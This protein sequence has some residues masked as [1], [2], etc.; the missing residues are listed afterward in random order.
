MAK[1]FGK[2]IKRILYE[3][4]DKAVCPPGNLK[5]TRHLPDIALLLK[6]YGECV[7]RRHQQDIEEFFGLWGKNTPDGVGYE[8]ER[9]KE[10]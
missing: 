7:T 9:R 8:K 3:L 2:G 10:W 4:R 1:F 5:Q 6:A